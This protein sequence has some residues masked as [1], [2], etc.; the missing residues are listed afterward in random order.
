[1]LKGIEFTGSQEKETA[2]AFF[3]IASHSCLPG[4]F[5]D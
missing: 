1:M 2:V 4:V 3:V 5:C